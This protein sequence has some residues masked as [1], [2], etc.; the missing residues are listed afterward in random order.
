MRNREHHPK[1]STG[2]FFIVLGLVLLI[3]TN[4]ILH[5]GSFA[6]YFTWQTVMIFIGILLL[7]NLHFTGGVLLIAAGTWF[8]LDQVFYDVPHYIRTL[9]WPGVVILLGLSFI[10]SSLFKKRPKD[11]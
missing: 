5:L 4:D 1:V 11:I 9:Y 2:L 7:V 10:V 8:L 6:S 3:A